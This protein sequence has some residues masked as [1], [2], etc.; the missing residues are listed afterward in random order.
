MQC[1]RESQQLAAL[2]V[3]PL[4]D[5]PELDGWQLLLS[6]GLKQVT[7]DLDAVSRLPHVEVVD[8]A[9]CLDGWAAGPLRRSGALLSGVLGRATRPF[10]AVSAGDLR[11]VLSGARLPVETLL[12]NSL[13]G[14]P[15]PREHGGPAPH[16]GVGDCG[17]GR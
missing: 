14:E 13:N 16:N 2:P 15:L 7:L 12:A 6:A 3:H 9:V 1:N 10:V 5:L 17:D 4:P 8:T 11:A